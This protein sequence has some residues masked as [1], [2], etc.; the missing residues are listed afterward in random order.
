MAREIR[1]LEIRLVERSGGQE[2]DIRFHPGT[3]RERGES[4]AQS[5]EK[6]PHASDPSL[7]ENVRKNAGEHHA[8]L[9]CVTH[10]GR[11][12]GAVGNNPPRTVR[13]P[14]DIGGIHGKPDVIFYGMSAAGSQ[15]GRVS[16]NE[17]GGKEAIRQ[18][19]LIP[20]QVIEDAIQKPNP[21]ANSFRDGL[22]FPRGEAQGDWIQ[23]PG[24]KQASRLRVV[25]R[26]VVVKNLSCLV[27]ASRN[28]LR[29]ETREESRDVAPVRA[30]AAVRPDHLVERHAL[31]A[32]AELIAQQRGTL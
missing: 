4:G 13:C 19:S 12:L 1:L 28:L 3:G 5:V 6:S 14:R 17:R 25:G 8:I 10:S 27:P 11:S 32:K 2:N 7:P 15:V 9:Q 20:I 26:P 30:D 23:L 18:E 31:G 21:L 29:S 22:P 24:S 16:E